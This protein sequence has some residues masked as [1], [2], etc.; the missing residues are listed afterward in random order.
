[1]PADFPVLRNIVVAQDKKTAL[2][3]AGPSL[4]ESYRLFGQWGLFRE[5]VGSEKD[6]LELEELLADRVIIGSPE[7]CAE[8]LTELYRQCG[9]TRLV[10]RVQ[11]MGMDQRVVLRTIELLAERVRPMV[12]AAL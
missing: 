7:E 6:E 3:E 11:W 2:R 10:A 8:T 5:V 1:M 4:A 12:E 9:A